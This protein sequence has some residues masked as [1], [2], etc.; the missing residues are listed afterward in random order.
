MRCYYAIV[1][2][3][4]QAVAIVCPLIARGEPSISFSARKLPASPRILE[5]P[6]TGTYEQ[7]RIRT[8]YYDYEGSVG[9]GNVAVRI[10]VSV[11]A[12]F[13]TKDINGAQE[14]FSEPKLFGSYVFGNGNPRMRRFSFTAPS[15][16]EKETKTYYGRRTQKRTSGTQHLGAVVFAS[17]NGE[18]KKIVSIPYNRSWEEHV[19]KVVEERNGGLRPSPQNR[20]FRLDFDNPAVPGPAND[21]QQ[22]K[23]EPVVTERERIPDTDATTPP[24]W[25]DDFYGAL[26]RAA[27]SGKLVFLVF[28]AGNASSNPR[29]VYPLRTLRLQRYLKENYEL[30]YIGRDC[31]EEKHSR[32]ADELRNAFDLR[33]E[34]D[35]SH[36]YIVS[37]DG[38][39]IADFAIPLYYTQN[40]G[41]D[42]FFARFCNDERSRR[43]MYRAEEKTK[44]MPS[45][46]PERA[47]I[48]HKTM[49]Q[50]DQDTVMT[51][52][53]RCAEEVV[54]I[55]PEYRKH[56][57]YLE[58]VRPLEN[59]FEKI[60]SEFEVE[61]RE[62]NSAYD[63]VNVNRMREN[64]R[65][66]YDRGGYRD[67]F[68]KLLKE[69]VEVS[70]NSEKLGLKGFSLKKLGKLRENFFSFIN[71]L[72]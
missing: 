49:M 57:P 3:V 60:K 69:I 11:R 59:S 7:E 5:Q 14:D 71:N 46:S 36:A 27:A 20:Q 50:I 26:G 72:K 32:L 22:E 55:C 1:A 35:A 54:R 38:T 62:L 56:Y 61:V 15:V 29:M 44:S 53:M 34:Y 47:N 42:K 10:E 24:G 18:I 9:C 31:K 6:R 41:M 65:F 52:F 16:Q 39:K 43:L 21:F 33:S 17:I 63:G 23:F 25:N 2:A 12:V 4:L 19:R 45:A 68:G 40:G 30:V 51:S 8:K 37:S 67:K 13:I 64:R 48:L 58:Y 70:A 28:G 66:L